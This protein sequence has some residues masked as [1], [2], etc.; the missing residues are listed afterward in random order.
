MTGVDQCLFG[1]DCASQFSSIPVRWASYA[2]TESF[3]EIK[4]GLVFADCTIGQPFS[5]RIEAFVRRSIVV[6]K[7]IRLRYK[8]TIVLPS[9]RN[10][11]YIPARDHDAC[12]T[13]GSVAC[14]TR[15]LLIVQTMKYGVFK[16]ARHFVLYWV[17]SAA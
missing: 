12:S 10:G 11:T 15:Y 6:D 8:E 17:Q 4:E 1:A 3:S 14:S 7:I 9:P 5:I 13:T 16:E 2:S